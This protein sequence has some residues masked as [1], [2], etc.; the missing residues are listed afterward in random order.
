M[1]AFLRRY[2]HY[3]NKSKCL[4]K[5][6]SLERLIWEHI[7]NRITES[8]SV[9]IKR[10]IRERMYICIRRGAQRRQQKSRVGS[11][12]MYVCYYVIV[13]TKSRF[14]TRHCLYICG[15]I[16]VS[17]RSRFWGAAER[18]VYKTHTYTPQRTTS[19]TV[20]S[21]C[22]VWI[23]TRATN[24]WRNP[25]NLYITVWPLCHSFSI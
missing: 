20:S 12:R 16:C 18:T 23:N 4:T 7:H 14:A 2:H 11:T 24:S 19:H 3:S 13:N 9:Y 6:S 15:Y 10:F 5:S 17:T 8:A 1:C 22:A 21:M 25:T